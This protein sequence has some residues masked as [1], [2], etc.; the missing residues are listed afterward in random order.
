[1]ENMF[2]RFCR[3]QS[4]ST[5]QICMRVFQKVPRLGQNRNVG[6]TYSIL[7]AIFLQNSLL[8]NIFSNPIIFFLCLYLLCGKQ[9]EIIVCLLAFSLSSRH[10]FT[11]CCFVHLSRNEGTNFL[12]MLYMIRVSVKIS[13]QTS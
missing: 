7:A 1:V 13:W 6:L 2:C 9:S 10:T 4:C 3:V 11:H 12:V 5:A 8:W